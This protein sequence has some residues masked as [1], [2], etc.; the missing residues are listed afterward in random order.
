M[1]SVELSKFFAILVYMYEHGAQVQFL[2]SALEE[3]ATFFF[4]MRFVLIITKIS[5]KITKID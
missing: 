5:T 1:H 4:E 3:L 2:S